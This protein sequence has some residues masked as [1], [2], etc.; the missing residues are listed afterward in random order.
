MK[1][2]LLFASLVL[3]LGAAATAGSRLPPPGTGAVALHPKG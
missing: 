3:L 1:R 2:K